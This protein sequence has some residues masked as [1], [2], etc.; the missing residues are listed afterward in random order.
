LRVGPSNHGHNKSE[1]FFKKAHWLGDP[2]KLILTIAKNGFRFSFMTHTFKSLFMTHTFHF[3]GE[4][5]FG[6]AKCNVDY[7]PSVDDDLHE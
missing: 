5:V 1:L 4:E 7:S 2:S 3:K 6:L